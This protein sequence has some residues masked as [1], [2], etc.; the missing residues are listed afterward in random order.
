MFHKC[1]FDNF[2]EHLRKVIWLF[3]YSSNELFPTRETYRIILNYISRIKTVNYSYGTLVVI[4]ELVNIVSTS[5][6]ISET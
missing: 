1:A 6:L 2:L 5:K 3:L 4:I